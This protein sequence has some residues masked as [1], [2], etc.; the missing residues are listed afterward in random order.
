MAFL[1]IPRPVVRT[2]LVVAL[3]VSSM[4]MANGLALCHGKEVTIQGTSGDDVIEGTPG[5]DVIAGRG[6]DDVI[7]GRGGSDIVCG[8]NG[9][10]ALYGN[11]GNDRLYGES[12]RD[13]ILGGSGADR[14]AGGPDRDRVSYADSDGPVVVN[15]VA[16][17]VKGADDDTI[18]SFRDVTGSDFDDT[19]KGSDESNDLRGGDGED[20][21]SGRKGNDVIR[22]GSGGDALNGGGG[23]DVIAGGP[24]SDELEGGTG[25]DQIEGGAGD[26]ILKGD[27]GSDRLFGARG[28]D[29]LIGGKKADLCRSGELLISCESGLKVFGGGVWTVPGEVP[30]GLYRNSSSSGGCYWARLSGFGGELD[31]IITNEF[32]FDRDIV[33]ITGSEEGFESSGC[34][35]W[36]NDL[37]PR[38]S[39]GSKMG[40]GAYLVGFEVRPGLWRNSNSSD[41]CYWERTSGFTNTLGEIHANNFTFDIQIVEIKKSDVGF[42]SSDCGTWTKIG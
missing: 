2:A 9:D 1:R 17:T 10:D 6:G 27:D 36:T 3:L 35:T 19:I 42:T 5:R 41:G 16:G 13:V 4:P 24:G 28:W 29:T 33:Q 30:P 20:T 21:I 40:S 31:D 25:A 7:R 23:S 12:G 38:K 34:G 37:S 18:S 22:G 26:D 32:T 8:G 14:L 39:P 15:L 11:K